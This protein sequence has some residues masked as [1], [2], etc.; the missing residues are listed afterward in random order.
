VFHVYDSDDN[1]YLDSKEMES[2]IE[3]CAYAPPH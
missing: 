1:G 2:I 3:V